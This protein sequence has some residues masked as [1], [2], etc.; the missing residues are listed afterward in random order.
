M[1]LLYGQTV[2][3]YFNL[4]TAPCVVTVAR[5]AEA[6]ALAALKAAI[7]RAAAGT[8]CCSASGAPGWSAVSPASRSR[9]R[10]SRC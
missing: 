7:E 10:P 3:A 6:S 2:T 4:L 1:R 5:E 9:G 8:A